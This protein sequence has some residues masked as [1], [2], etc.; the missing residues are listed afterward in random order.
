MRIFLVRHA[1]SVDR[2]GMMPDAARYLSAR[3]RV[4]FRDMA[5]RFRETGARPVHILTSPLVRAVQ[6]AEI[7][8]EALRYEG[9]VVVAPQLAPG[10][11]EEGLNA[12]LDECPG[13][14]QVALIGHEPDLGRVLTRMLSLPRDQAMRKGSI[15][16]LDVPDAGKRLR[17]NFV[18][19]LD[20]E[21]R[22]ADR[23]EISG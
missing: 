3:G 17:A 6:T 21:K 10:F 20:G 5:V 12:I 7:L 22:I 16:A 1:D 13:A 14:D 2:V 11:D 19:M 23:S 8:S 4:S 9:A 15:A 18:W